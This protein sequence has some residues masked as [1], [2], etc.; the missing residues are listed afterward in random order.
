MRTKWESIRQMRKIHLAIASLASIAL[1]SA[2]QL[3]GQRSNS[4]IENSLTPGPGAALNGKWL[5]TDEAARG[6]YEAEFK[7]GEFVSRNPNTNKPLA[8]GKY[9]IVSDKLVDL[10]F[11]GAATNTVVKAK[12]DRQTEDTMYCVPTVGSPFNLKRS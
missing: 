3:G 2:C 8:Q 10:E 9:V 1:L 5:P 12:C 6:V 7:D 11:V 4:G